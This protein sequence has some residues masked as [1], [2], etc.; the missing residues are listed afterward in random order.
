MKAR[1]I[2]NSAVLLILSTLAFLGLASRDSAQAA[3]GGN[4]KVESTLVDQISANGSADFIMRFSDQADLSPAYTMDWDARGEYVYNTL[5]ETASH[6]Q[7]NAKALLDAQGLTYQT[8]IAGNELYVFGSS[9]AATK[10]QKAFDEL[11]VVNAL[12][13][14]PEVSAIRSIRTY[15]IDP[16]E[17]SKPLQNIT[18]AGDLLSYHVLMTVGTTVTGVVEPWIVDTKADQFWSTFGVRGEGIVVANIDTGVDYTHI[19]LNPNYKCLANPSS[20]TCWYDPGTQDCSGLNGGPCDAGAPLYHGTHVMGTM[21]GDDNPSLQWI[22]GMAPNAQWIACLGLPGGSGTDLDINGC[23]DWLLAPGGNPANRPQVV[24]N[25]WGSPY[26]YNGDAWFLPKVNAW[27][28]AGI[29]PAFS[30]G[31]DGTA[32][33]STL[34]S[35]GDYQEVFTSAA[36][37]SARVIATFSSRGPSDFGHDPYTKPNITSPGVNIISA[38]P[39]NTWQTMSGTSM[40]SPH[41]AGAVALLW[42]LKPALKGNIDATF[43][44]LQNTADPPHDGGNCGAPPDGQGN[45]TYGYGHLNVLAAG[46]VGSVVTVIAPPLNATLRPNETRSIPITIMNSTPNPLNWS[47]YEVLR[48]VINNGTSSTA[49]LISQTP[50]PVNLTLDSQIASNTVTNLPKVQGS[51]TLVLD[52]GTSESS[53][54]LIGNNLDYQFIWLNRFTPQPADFPFAINQ[55]QVFFDKLKGVYFDDPI[56]LVVYQDTDGDPSNGGVLLATFHEKVKAADGVTWSVYDLPSPVL[57]TGPGDVLIGVINRYA[58]SG[59]SPA[60]YPATLDTDVPKQRSWIGWWVADPPDPAILPP[61]QVFHLID[62]DIPPGGNWLIR[63]SGEALGVPWLS[64]NTTSG[65]IPAG[66]SQVV[67]VVFNATGLTPDIYLADLDILTDNPSYNRF[68]LPVRLA[69]PWIYL[70]LI[71]K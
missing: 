48:S 43:Q 13:A 15:T 67:N 52:D 57:I 39:T 10:G 45:Y 62:V 36:H 21:V 1:W 40:A 61:D 9:Q 24:N 63:A 41:T 42:S 64:E 49:L 55:I 37:G 54:G 44:L 58:Q 7:V 70:P 50:H 22:V 38:K 25:S 59:V 18:W 12:A 19:A 23:A 68:I 32:G 6:S 51:P 60:S 20:P 28:A 47:I 31:N 16:V 71:N 53:V 35:P 27:R 56:D 5:K 14:L 34:S 17:V 3:A 69:V 29:F 4:Q 8:F 66:Q 26:I 33:C 65:T 30:A 2:I 11:A 46:N